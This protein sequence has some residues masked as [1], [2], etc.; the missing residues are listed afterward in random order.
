MSITLSLHAN[1]TETPIGDLKQQLSFF[2][3]QELL[4]ST[5]GV[6]I[7]YSLTQLPVD[8]QATSV[9]EL[10][11]DPTK[12]DAENFDVAAEIVTDLL[13]DMDTNSDPVVRLAY[14]YQ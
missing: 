5:L 4:A 11:S 12:L 14:V 2:T 10:V 3:V 9:E 6:H 13:R 1:A 7:F 8:Q